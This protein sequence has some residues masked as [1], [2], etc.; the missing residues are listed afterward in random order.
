VNAHKG[1]S[2]TAAPA[3]PWPASGSAR[4]GRTDRRRRCQSSSVTRGFITWHR[5]PLVISSA[6]KHEYVQIEPADE[7]RWAVSW[8]SILLGHLDENHPERGLIIPRR[9]RGAKEVSA[10]SLL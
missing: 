4:G 2:A 7:V 6:L 3:S 10:M 9:R 8:G 5:R 1:S